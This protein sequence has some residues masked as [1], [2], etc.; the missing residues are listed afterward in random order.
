M[1]DGHQYPEFFAKNQKQVCL[2]YYSEFLEYTSSEL[3][4]MS[5]LD[6]IWI[7]SVSDNFDVLAEAIQER[8]EI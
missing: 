5:Q 7:K 4:F 6:P 3:V 1:H 2:N 8:E